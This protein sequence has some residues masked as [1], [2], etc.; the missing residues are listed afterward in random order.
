MEMS[1][2]RGRS[3]FWGMRRE[4]L[5]EI[6]EDLQEDLQDLKE[7]HM[8]VVNLNVELMDQLKRQSEMTQELYRRLKEKDGKKEPDNLKVPREKIGYA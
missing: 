8:K 3:S 4:D 6:I 1:M 5:E 2:S 7:R